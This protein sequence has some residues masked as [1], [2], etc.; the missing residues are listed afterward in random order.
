MPGYSIITT[1]I[2]EILPIE[3]SA[4]WYAKKGGQQF[5][6]QLIIREGYNTKA[7]MQIFFKIDDLRVIKPS[8]CKVISES[9]SVLNS[10]NY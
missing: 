7:G 5:E 6:A 3:V 8:S 1:Y 4:K 10:N 9:K 2:I